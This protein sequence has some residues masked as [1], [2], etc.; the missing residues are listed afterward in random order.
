MQVSVSHGFL[1]A[2]YTLSFSA[3]CAVTT[4]MTCRGDTYGRS[5]RAR[6]TPCCTGV[7]ST[8][9]RS[10]LLTTKKPS[11]RPQ[12]THERVKGDPDKKKASYVGPSIVSAYG[13]KGKKYSIEEHSRSRSQ[14]YP[15]SPSHPLPHPGQ[16]RR[17]LRRQLLPS[18]CVLLALT[19][20]YGTKAQ[21]KPP[22]FILRIRRSALR[23]FGSEQDPLH[24][25]PF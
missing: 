5:L 7:L 10:R 3:C 21:T 2:H 12:L 1:C 8:L 17:L 6:H 20:S 9:A 16:L 25:R 14:P 15:Y 11:S 13:S 23:Y 18:L 24:S 22:S 4:T 19:A